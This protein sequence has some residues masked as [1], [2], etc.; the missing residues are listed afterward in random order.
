MVTERRL[1]P[2]LAEHLARRV[3]DD[4]GEWPPVDLSNLARYLGVRRIHRTEITEDGRT[5]WIEG[6]P[7][8]ELRIDRSSTRTRFTLAHELGHVL[9]QTDRTSAARRTNS[10]THNDEETMCDWIAAALLMPSDWVR[11]YA[12]RQPLTLSLLR[13]VAHRAEVSLAATAVRLSEVGRRTCMLLRWRRSK[14][15]WILA[16]QA[17]V[18]ADIAGFIELANETNELMS[19]LPRHRDTW[20][21]IRVVSDGRRFHG[22]AQLDLGVMNSLML[23]TELYKED[24]RPHPVMSR[25]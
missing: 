21:S 12:V 2:G 1:Q 6:R 3:L 18:P 25:R 17:G 13:L 11:P 16:G 9:L 10:L 20:S 8:I 15:R 19:T 22:T 5:I 4:A 14:D 7:E 24:E 23:V